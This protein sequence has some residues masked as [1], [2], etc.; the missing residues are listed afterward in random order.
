VN[1]KAKPWAFLVLAAAAVLGF[2]QT[3]AAMQAEDCQGCHSEPSLVSS[4]G[5]PLYIDP[6][7]Y[8]STTHAQEGC[9][10]CHRSVTDSHPDDGVKVS[11]AVCKDCH[12]EVEAEYA[13]SKHADNASCTDCHNPHDVRSATAVSGFDENRQCAS[14]HDRR[15]TAAAHAKWLPQA[16]LHLEALPCI[17]CHT[18]SQDY[19]IT[20]YLEDRDK[21]PRPGEA[22]KLATY[23]SLADTA[24]SPNIRAIIDRNGDNLIALKELREFHGRARFEGLRLWG[25]MTPQKMTHTYDILQN[26]WDCSFCHASGPKAMQTSFVAFPQEDGSYVRVPVEKGAILDLLYGTP[27]FYMMGATRNDRLSGIGLAIIA[28]G[29]AMP[30]GHGTLRFLTRRNRKEH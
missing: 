13:K 27:D 30:I 5:K 20:L 8:A 25:M 2:S 22:K 7:K 21:P 15:E 24:G 19:V 26:R 4:S 11:K 17:T 23:K 9:P 10:S 16:G 28:A 1:G 18:G 14:C 6:V 12:E 29:L 3:A